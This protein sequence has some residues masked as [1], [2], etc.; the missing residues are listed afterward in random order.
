MVQLLHMLP[1]PHFNRVHAAIYL[2]SLWRKIAS[3]KHIGSR[4]YFVCSD[5]RSRFFSGNHISLVGEEVLL[6][7]TR[8]V[9]LV[10]SNGP[11][12]WQDY[13]SWSH[14]MVA[15]ALTTPHIFLTESLLK[16]NIQIWIT[17]RENELCSVKSDF[18]NHKAISAQSEPIAQWILHS[19]FL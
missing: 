11:I 19:E 16:R 6:E 13:F 12:C 10:E 5:F 9:F 18:K 3:D 1:L 8:L 4:S 15:K 7:L 14:G 2:T 17:F